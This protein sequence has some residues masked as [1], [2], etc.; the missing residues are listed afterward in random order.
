MTLKKTIQ[1]I[2]TLK[3]QGASAVAKATLLGMRDFAKTIK[4]ARPAKFVKEIEKAGRALAYVRPTEP[5]AQNLFEGMMKK[6]KQA[7]KAGASP[8][9]LK[10]IVNFLVRHDLQHL[11]EELKQVVE[12]GVKLIKNGDRI[13]T[14]CHSS[15]VEQILIVAH[16]QGKKFKVFNTE[17]RPLFQGRITARKLA[18][19]G[20]DDTLILDSEADKLLNAKKVNKVLIGADVLLGD[21]S[22]INKVG[23]FGLCED[24]YQNKIPVYVATSLL[25]LKRG[26]EVKI[27][28]RESGEVWEEAPR[29]VKIVNLAFD[30][31]PAKFIK[32]I[33][34][35]RGLLKPKEIKRFCLE[36]SLTKFNRV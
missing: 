26:G 36:E 9:D 31:V 14:H 24:A 1:D 2:K 33:I 6:L 20:V 27:E 10:E 25:K 15:T 17:T 4:S 3:I 16:K 5:M 23:S 22:I 28:Q 34:T 8:A 29:K 30:K 18:Q 12:A 32:G 35:E 13:L 21:G 11:E 7:Q 19:A